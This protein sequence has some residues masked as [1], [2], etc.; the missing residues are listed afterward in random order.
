MA[1]ALCNPLKSSFTP[2]SSATTIFISG[3]YRAFHCLFCPPLAWTPICTGAS[4]AETSTPARVNERGK[5]KK[6]VVNRRK[7]L[8][9]NCLVD[10]VMIL[11]VSP[12]SFPELLVSFLGESR[13]L[14]VFD[15]SG[16]KTKQ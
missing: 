16:T 8:D 10:E 15:Q 4:P 3:A 7:L 13:S 1:G 6:G 14:A 2:A 9:L 5:R 12:S 11:M